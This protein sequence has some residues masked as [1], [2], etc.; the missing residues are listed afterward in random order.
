MNDSEQNK[1]KICDEY[2]KTNISVYKLHQKYNIS[3]NS[4]KRILSNKGINIKDG[5]C[6][7]FSEQEK[8]DIVDQ[9]NKGRSIAYLHK[10]YNCDELNI[11][12][13]LH[14]ANII[15]RTH[16]E[17]LKLIKHTPSKQQNINIDI[18]KHQ[19][20]N[21]RKS[22]NSLTKI[23]N[24][25]P[26][27]IKEILIQHNIK[28]RN[29]VESVYNS[30][31]KKYDK[32]I[33]LSKTHTIREIAE[34]TKI[35]KGCIRNT[36]KTHNIKSVKRKRK[37][38]N[39]IYKNTQ[40]I[41]HMFNEIH[42]QYKYITLPTSYSSEI[43]IECP[44]HG[45]FKQKAYIHRNGAGCPLCGIESKKLKEEEVKE[46]IKQKFPGYDLSNIKYN[47][48]NELIEITCPIHGNFKK[49]PQSL[50]YGYGCPRC[51]L[52]KYEK[53]IEDFLV[54]NG[55]KYIHHYKIN[56]Q[57]NWFEL[58]FYLPELQKGIEVNGVF[59][60]SEAVGRD[61]KY[62]LN[63][64][65]IC[66]DNNIH[67]IHI[68]THLLD[69]KRNIVFDRLKNILNI[70][71]KIIYARHCFISPIKTHDA[72]KFLELNHLQ[73]PTNS[74]ICYGLFYDNRL[75][76]VMTFSKMRA[77]FNKSKEVNVFELVRFACEKDYRVL[78]GA[79]KLLKHFI[80][81][82]KP[83]KII[84][85]A[86][87]CW[88]NGGFY[89]SIGFEFDHYSNP[90]YWYVKDNKVYHRYQFAKHM[91]EKQLKVFDPKL[92]EWENMKINKYTRY[93]DCGNI[94]YIKILNN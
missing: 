73:G 13:I 59:W 67:L 76:S 52:S 35:S 90:G 3:Y 31:H 42:G 29:L 36:L 78:G 23:F 70:P 49:T 28:T 48:I 8:D 16:K 65:K 5:R 18:L 32:I 89:E 85:Y 19:Y 45:L 20:I 57:N 37:V 41:L 26:K 60:H 87:R 93:W 80:T 74:N 24:I 9:Y 92:S 44:A 17:S 21:E 50:F 6:R 62:H 27:T 38:E 88:S 83:Q 2:I 54:E 46:R 58:D 68:F 47:G 72:K 79:S 12:K 63:K 40:H 53:I 55:I 82:Y 77:I 10:L 7:D 14:Q 81:D 4:I 34:K 30:N 39:N 69:I 15:L 71:G 51:S 84:T 25:S 64:T 66:E 75:V 86:D 1:Q 11:K 22:L 33:K 43:Q 56:Y 61:K 94:V 91:L